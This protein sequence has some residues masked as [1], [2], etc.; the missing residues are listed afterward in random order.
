MRK[1]TI[2]LL[3]FIFL[4][5]L[6]GCGNSSP[7]ASETQLSGDELF[8]KNLRAGLE[9][10]W[11]LPDGDSAEHFKQLVKA[12]KDI[13]GSVQDYS[14]EDS[15]LKQSANDYCAALDNQEKAAALYSIDY[16]EYLKQWH[17]GYYD[18]L[19]LLKAFVEKY[20]FTVSDEYTDTLNDMVQ[21]GSAILAE[22]NTIEL[23]KTAIMGS[24][25]ECLG[26]PSYQMLLENPTDKD[27]SDIQVRI[28]VFDKDNVQ[29]DEATEYINTWNAGS[30]V[31]GEFYFDNK[32][33]HAE[34]T[35]QH[36]SSI[37]QDYT[38]SDPF[39]LVI[40]DNMKIVITLI[41]TLPCE[42]KTNDYKGRQVALCS[43]SSFDYEI[44]YWNNGKASIE[45]R[46]SGEKLSDKKRG[47]YSR[48]CEAGYILRDEKGNQVAKDEISLGSMVVG[49]Q[50]TN[51]I[52]Y[53]S[54]IAPGNYTLELIDSH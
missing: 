11:A 8:L 3:V 43:I 40:E 35:I 18:R 44:S 1:F 6:F 49:D 50:F 38:L 32:F 13:L 10:R 4:F 28:R 22:R 5:S 54:D 46:V 25:L 41:N 37:L 30:K 14:F 52:E 7:A 9:A 26:G 21:K 53:L 12:E 33:D 2:L 47:S 45:L 42:I 19:V 15:E 24:K 23:L 27:M 39:S 29:V 34:C 17:N 36:Y 20:N 16:Q 51:K 48:Y 31:R